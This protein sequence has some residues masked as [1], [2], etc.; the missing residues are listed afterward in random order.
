MAP[1][2]E[3]E[4]TTVNKWITLSKKRDNHHASRMTCP[5]DRQRC[6]ITASALISHQLKSNGHKN[7]CQ[8][9]HIDCS[10]PAWGVLFSSRAKAVD[11]VAHRAK[12][13]RNACLP[14]PVVRP[15]EE[16]TAADERDRQAAAKSPWLG[17]AQ[18]LPS[19]KH[20]P[21]QSLFTTLY[22]RCASR[23]W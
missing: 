13:C 22:P 14:G 16:D 1:S 9:R 17:T 7:P 21:T 23:R 20:D 10:C 3:G 18:R 6:C 8:K 15:S 4:I 19:V 2:V 11:F 5:H 12:C